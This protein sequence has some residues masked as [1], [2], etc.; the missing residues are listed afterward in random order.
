MRDKSK[1]VITVSRQIGSG[2][3]YIGKQLAQQLNI[4]Y[5]DREILNQAAKQ[6]SV[7]SDLETELENMDEK[8]PTFWESVLQLNR[9][10]N[11]DSYIPPQLFVPT[12]EELF[13]V[14]EEIIRRTAD[15]SPA[16]I[17]GR[18]G[19]YIL[20]DHPDHV[21]IFLYADAE[22]RSKRLS[23]LYDVP[24]DA[25]D[26]LILQSD[27][28]RAHYHHRLTGKEWADASQYDL[29]VDTGRAGIDNTVK[30]I[31]QYLEME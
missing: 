13:R 11:T 16:V 5:M 2:G 29:C 14:E 4:L 30:L 7:L 8:V 3:A 28:E 26:K 23:R 15:E 24:R 18:C 19:S 22:F 6:L 17:I 12:S 1:I 20:R 10:S 31:L 25:A 27:T 21:S 9:Y